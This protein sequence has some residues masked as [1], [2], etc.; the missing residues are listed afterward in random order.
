M[1]PSLAPIPLA[2]SL[3]FQGKESIGRSCQIFGYFNECSTGN[4]AVFFINPEIVLES[5]FSLCLSVFKQD[6]LKN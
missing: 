1:H 5:R 4:M 3:P 6:Y 2:L